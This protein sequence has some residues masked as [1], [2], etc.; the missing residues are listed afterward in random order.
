MSLDELVSSY[1]D[2]Y[3]SYHHHKEQMA[4][5]VSVLY[6]GAATAVFFTGPRIWNYPASNLLTTLVLIASFISAF[7]FVWWQ[8]RQREFAAEMVA[9]CTKLAAQSVSS[10]L[11]NP[12]LSETEYRR[13]LFPAVLV[14]ELKAT[15]NERRSIRRFISGPRLS[16]CI[17][18]LAIVL[19]SLAALASIWPLKLD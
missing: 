7:A 6:L 8:M 2:Y 15:R 5:A 1:R 19:W 9:A 10:T 12:D 18:Y 14:E 16:E 17:T 3:G 4:Y 13:H 11:A